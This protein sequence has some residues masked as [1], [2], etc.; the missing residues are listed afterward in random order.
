MFVYM[1]GHGAARVICCGKARTLDPAH[2]QQAWVQDDLAKPGDTLYVRLNVAVK[3]RD[4]EHE[5][6]VAGLPRPFAILEPQ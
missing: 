4:S 1:R 2:I 5:D 3:I 6:L